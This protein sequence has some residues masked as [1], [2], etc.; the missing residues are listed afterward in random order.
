MQ[1]IDNCGIFRP[2]KIKSNFFFDFYKHNVNHIKSEVVSTEDFIKNDST[3]IRITTDHACHSKFEMFDGDSVFRREVDFFENSNLKTVQW[4]K[5]IEVLVGRLEK[6]R[7]FKRL[8]S[9]KS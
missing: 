6:K 2:F 5:G 8:R 7:K 3:L 4:D 9:I 1:R